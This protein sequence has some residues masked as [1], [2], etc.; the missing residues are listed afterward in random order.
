MLDFSIRLGSMVA[1]SVHRSI[2]TLSAFPISIRNF[3]RGLLLYFPP[4][5]SER[6]KSFP[7]PNGIIPIDG[8][9]LGKV[10]ESITDNIQPTVPSPPQAALI[11]E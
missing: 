5:F 9:P 3:F 2:V 10:I 6:D 4:Q 11:L 8:R 1:F 7:V